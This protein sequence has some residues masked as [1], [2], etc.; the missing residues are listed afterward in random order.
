MPTPTATSD[1]LDLRCPWPEGL[2][3]MFMG[4]SISRYQYLSLMQF[5]RYGR[6]LGEPHSE[7]STG[8]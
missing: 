7:A 1:S 2:R 8:M 6:W 3:L 5:L 4:G